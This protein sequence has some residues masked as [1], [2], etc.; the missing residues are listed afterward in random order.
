VSRSVPAA[1]Q[2]HIVYDA[3]VPATNAAPEPALARYLGRDTTR[4]IWIKGGLEPARE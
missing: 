3:A 2:V 4:A 1:V